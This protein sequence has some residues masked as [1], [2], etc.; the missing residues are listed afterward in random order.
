MGGLLEGHEDA[1]GVSHQNGFFD[2]HIL[3]AEF[4]GFPIDTRLCHFCSLNAVESEA[5]FM[6]ERPKIHGA[7]KVFVKS[8][9][10]RWSRGSDPSLRKLSIKSFSSL[11]TG[12]YFE[13]WVQILGPLLSTSQTLKEF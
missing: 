7:S 13:S 5:H 9:K 4:G 8:L 10:E 11:C 1:Y 3:L 12:T 6:L 2:N